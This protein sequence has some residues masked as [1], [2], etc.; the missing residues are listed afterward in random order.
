MSA[1]KSI[2][3]RRKIKPLAGYL[4]KKSPRLVLGKRVW[5]ARFFVLKIPSGKLLYYE[6]KSSTVPLGIIPVACM[7]SITREPS[8]GDSRFTFVIEGQEERTFELLADS[9]ETASHWVETLNHFLKQHQQVMPGAKDQM[10]GKF[11][12]NDKGMRE[13]STDDEGIEEIENTNANEK[14]AFQKSGIRNRKTSLSRKFSLRFNIMLKREQRSSLII[15]RQCLL[16]NCAND[17]FKSGY[18]SHHYK[19]LSQATAPCVLTKFSMHGYPLAEK[20]YKIGKNIGEGGFATVYAATCIKKD[21]KFDHVAVKLL[22][23]DKYHDLNDLYLEVSV[24][25]KMQHRNIINLLG[26]FVD[27]RQQLWLILP[28][29]AGGSCDQ[30]LQQFY[31]KGLNDEIVIATLLHYVLCGVEYLHNDGYAHRD[32]KAANILISGTGQVILADFG[33]ATFFSGRKI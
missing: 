4:K 28:L 7:K 23:M 20:E 32:L 2:S 26:S 14:I 12:K 25:T 19:K 31:P 15:Q 3:P 13:T 17:L 29:M 27:F 8:K 9:P 5:Q 30:I 33:A 22:N 6:K 11:W 16:K 1:P 24:M 21:G 18:C 10:S